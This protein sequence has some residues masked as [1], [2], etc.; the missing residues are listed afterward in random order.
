MKAPL[1]VLLVFVNEADRWQDGQPLYQV[2]VERLRQL[3][4]AGA[5]ATAGIMGFGHHHRIHHKGLFGIADDRPVTVMAL[6]EETTLRTAARAIRPLV[7]E[8]LLVLLDAELLADEPP[9]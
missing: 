4:I 2:L 7:Q 9:A 3:G 6:D 8:G 1:K 5:T